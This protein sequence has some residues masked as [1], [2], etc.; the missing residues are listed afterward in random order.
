[1]STCAAILR[2]MWWE[3]HAAS[4]SGKMQYIHCCFVVPLSCVWW[5]GHN[6]CLVD[7]SWGTALFLSDSHFWLSILSVLGK[8]IFSKQ[9]TGPPWYLYTPLAWINIAACFWLYVQPTSTAPASLQPC[10][11]DT[12]ACQSFDHISHWLNL[13]AAIPYA[14]R[15]QHCSWKLLHMGTPVSIW[16]YQ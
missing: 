8:E 13:F 3:S 11:D 15:L 10:F 4:I 14:K 5:E 9:I 16:H 7:F 12:L 1:M 6:A 2:N